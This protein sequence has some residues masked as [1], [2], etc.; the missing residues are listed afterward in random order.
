MH[1]PS[2]PDAA[3]A[4]SQSAPQNL[5]L[6]RC[7]PIH[8]AA[9]DAGH[10]YGVWAAGA[11][12]KI[13]FHDGAT[14]I[15]YL[16]KDY[17][18]NQPWSWTTT[19]VRMGSVE[20]AT[21]AVSERR[22][23]YEG[24]R[25]EYELGSA[26]EAWDVRSSGV[27]QTFVIAQRHGVGDLVVRGRV[28][29]MLSSAAVA[30]AHQ[31]LSFRDHRGAEL[32]TYGAATAVD[33]L[34]QRRAMTTS[35]ENGE[36][37]LRLDA[38]WLDGASFPVVVDP[39]VGPGALVS[40]STRY[41][42]DLVREAEV[43]VQPNWAA[44]SEFA[45]STDADV[46]VRRWEDGGTLG[47][48]PFAD[49]TG[50]WSSR[51]PS[52][53]YNAFT[54]Y[55]VCAFDRLF[56]SN[57]T[58][59]I[60]VHPHLRNDY[61]FNSSVDFL[62][63]VENVWRTDVGGTRSNS[64]GSDVM[65]A[66][67]LEATGAFQNTSSSE[68]YAVTYDPLAGS[69]GTPVSIISSVATD[70]ER[71]S[72]NQT[73]TDLGGNPHWVVA[74]QSRSLLISNDDLDLFARQ[75]DRNGVVSAPIAVDNAYVGHKFAPKI[76]GGGGRYLCA[77]VG[78]PIGLFGAPTGTVGRALRTARIDWPNGGSGSTPY[79]ATS[80][81]TS[82]SNIIDIGDVGFDRNSRSHWLV[83]FRSTAS[84]NI[85]VHVCG[86]RGQSMRVDQVFSAASFNNTVLGGVSFDSINN[87]FAIAYGYSS[88]ISSFT[89]TN[90]FVYPTVSS[91]T[92]SGISCSPAQI[93]WVGSQ[94]IG[95]EFGRV[96]VN[97]AASDSI[98]VAVLANAT[99][100]APLANIPPI[101]NGCWLLV[102]N[103]GPNFLGLFDL[104]VGANVSWDLP[105]PESLPIETYYMQGWHTVGGGNFDFVSTQRLRLPTVK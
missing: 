78:A 9:A 70:N 37:C 15:P 83:L 101:Q 26:I 44:W 20:L 56:S 45:S 49:I 11:R 34:G 58:R 51:S 90:R 28:A 31:S 25:A 91:A 79:G 86:Y 12:Y 99:A 17:P 47:S 7:V 59:R 36:I 72:I 32:V 43:S 42:L 96:R 46:Y 22:L 81:Q 69:F 82:G 35:F 64:A 74:Y 103:T 68:I 84:N 23:R 53:G 67:Q 4:P 3:G 87:A 13:S 63:T 60:R 65:I 52:M 55:T 88:V 105:L 5:A 41:E 73:S 8:T 85:N 98:H 80:I 77:F 33:A 75:I 21:R 10:D 95:S 62:N 76:D 102:A 97:G 1:A 61:V 6:E 24:E 39:I 54:N 29:T 27:E 89:A 19:S 93:D 18:H 57:S 50:S 94:Q 30:A 104:R 40:G 48:G 71:P 66:Y 92:S 38:A 2:E 100:S 14:F 16:G